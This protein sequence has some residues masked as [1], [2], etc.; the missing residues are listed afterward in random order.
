MLEKKCAPV[1]IPTLNRK[2]HLER[3]INSLLRNSMAKETEVY[4]S[5]D[6]PPTEKYESGYN[7][8][9]EYLKREIDGFKKV[10]LFFQTKIM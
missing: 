4:I 6:F 1:L 2:E 5:I 9:V 10:N 8:V 7:E 3:C